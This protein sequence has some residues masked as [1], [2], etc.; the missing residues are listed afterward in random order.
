VGRLLRLLYK[1]VVKGRMNMHREIQDGLEDF[2]AGTADSNGQIRVETHL[3]E[4]A[5]CRQEVESMRE[6]SELF[7]S[8]Q[9]PDPPVP[10]PGFYARVNRLI[11]EQ[12]PAPFWGAALEPF[13]GRRLALASL[14]VMATLGTILVSRETE[15]YAVGSSP[16][17]V[18]A[19]EKD[20]PTV[21][22]GP[23]IDRDQMLYTLASHRQ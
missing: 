11:E 19:A 6:M 22:A 4:C 13:F 7:T 23:A 8:L 3:R 9:S 17:M 16:E 10:A 18:L 14:L 15:E 1:L 2:L 12:R 21:D 5:E 20:A